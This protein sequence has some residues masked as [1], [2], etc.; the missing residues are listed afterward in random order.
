ME[1]NII[2]KYCQT[3]LLL[4][5]VKYSKKCRSRNELSNNKKSEIFYYLILSE[6]VKY[7]KAFFCLLNQK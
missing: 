3:K 5:R 1:S 7:A 2:N 4:S 6:N